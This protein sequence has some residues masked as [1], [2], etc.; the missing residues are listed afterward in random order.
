MGD[1]HDPERHK[2][3]QQA[4]MSD[5]RKAPRRRGRLRSFSRPLGVFPLVKQ[6]RDRVDIGA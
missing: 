5:P 3:E 6:W 2:G 1:D 4:A